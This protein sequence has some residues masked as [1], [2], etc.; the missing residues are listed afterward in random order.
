[1]AYLGAVE[2]EW[3]GAIDGD[4]EGLVAFAGGDR[5]EPAPNTSLV[6][7]AGF[8]EAALGHRVGFR[9]KMKF[10]LL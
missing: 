2:P 10:E 3:L 1:M 9:V 6:G 4:S 8:V 7:Y 5:H